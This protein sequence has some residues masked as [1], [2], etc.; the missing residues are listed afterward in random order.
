MMNPTS[1]V[2]GCSD[3]ETEPRLSFVN[4][5]RWPE[6]EAEFLKSLSHEPTNDN[7]ER[8]SSSLHKPYASR[9]R[10]IRSYP[11]CCK[12]PF[13]R[14]TKKRMKIEMK[15]VRA[16]SFSCLNGAFEFITSMRCSR[17]SKEKEEE[18][19]FISMQIHKSPRQHRMISLLFAFP[20]ATDFSVRL[21]LIVLVS[22]LIMMKSLN[23]KKKSSIIWIG[24]DGKFLLE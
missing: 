2:A 14:R 19:F 16:L 1:C 12:E 23:I 18:P 6:A 22:L 17:A 20:I 7:N 11:F 9:Q 3:A 10:Y 15:K 24:Y 21:K 13:L 5:H 8:P 4:L